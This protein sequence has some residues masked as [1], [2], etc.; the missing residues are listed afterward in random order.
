[1][2]PIYRKDHLDLMQLDLDDKCAVNWS[3]SEFFML[4]QIVTAELNVKFLVGASDLCLYIWLLSEVVPKRVSLD[5][6]K[7]DADVTPAFSRHFTFYSEFPQKSIILLFRISSHFSNLVVNKNN[8]DN[9]EQANNFVQGKEMILQQLR[10]TALPICSDA[11][12]N[13]VRKHLEDML[14]RRL[15]FPRELANDYSKHFNIYFF[16]LKVRCI[17]YLLHFF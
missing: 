17:L 10:H 3:Y 15:G 5:T 4:K 2:F 7:K 16:V 13:H 6:S 9:I 1:M 11:A 8:N 12:S 14:V